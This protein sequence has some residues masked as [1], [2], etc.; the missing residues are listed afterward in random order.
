LNCSNRVTGRGVPGV[1]GTYFS[2]TVPED[3]RLLRQVHDTSPQVKTSRETRWGSSAAEHQALDAAPAAFNYGA[4][5]NRG[6]RFG[7]CVLVMN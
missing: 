5:N 1:P 6:W 3:L 7:V 4:P 2:L